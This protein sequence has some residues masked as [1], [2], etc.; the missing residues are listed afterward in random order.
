MFRNKI[1]IFIQIFFTYSYDKKLVLNINLN[2][3]IWK[4]WFQDNVSNDFNTV[5]LKKLVSMVYII[6][7]YII[8]TYFNKE[9][10]KLY[11]SLIILWSIYRLSW[12]QITQ[13][14][15]SS[16]IQDSKNCNYE[17]NLKICFLN[18]FYQEQVL[19][20]SLITKQLQRYT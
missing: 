1:N 7:S 19:A 5:K 11:L 12:N 18:T 4:P 20:L 6:L 9:T 17:Q 16:K 2:I 3:Q 13:F 10:N 8:I 15:R 14:W